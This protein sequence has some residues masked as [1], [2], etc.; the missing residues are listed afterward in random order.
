MSGKP[1]TIPFFENSPDNLHC[2]QSCVKSLLSLYFPDRVF[3]DNEIDEKTI[4]EGWWTWLP[5]AVVWLHELGLDVRLYSS[6][7][8]RRFSQEGESYMK[9][10]KTE[11]MYLKEKQNGAYDNLPLVQLAYQKMMSCDLLEQSQLSKENL[12]IELESEHTFAVGKTI[13][14]WLDGR[15][16]LSSHYVVVIKKY[17]PGVWRVHD[18]GLPGRENRK[19]PQSFNEYNIFGDVLLVKGVIEKA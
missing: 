18:P 5:P 2:L 1:K 11:E 13:H 17:A 10:F 6:F 19:I 8:Y 7:D 3:D 12:E 9:E 16:G 15:P 4:Q 14:E